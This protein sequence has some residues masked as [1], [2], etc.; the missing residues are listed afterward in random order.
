MVG[1]MMKQALLT[2]TLLC[3]T[4]TAHAACYADY[5]AKQDGPLR[6]HYG[7]IELPDGACNSKSAAE[8][9]AKRRLDAAGWTLLKL[10]TT[11]DKDGLNARKSEAGAHFLAY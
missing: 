10:M 8:A 5:K 3:A 4:S 6:L 9:A 1:R 11:F 2:L 7:V